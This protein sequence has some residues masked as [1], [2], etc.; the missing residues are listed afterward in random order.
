ML[1][2]Y[3]SRQYEMKERAFRSQFISLGTM[4]PVIQLHLL[5]CQNFTS[6]ANKYQFVDLAFPMI[7]RLSAIT[8]LNQPQR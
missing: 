2:L 6:L 1:C 7:E 8:Q 5:M 4:L 3:I